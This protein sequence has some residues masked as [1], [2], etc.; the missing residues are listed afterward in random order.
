M[1]GNFSRNK[2]RRAEYTVRDHFRG[3]GYTCDRVPLSGA[4][5]GFKGDLRVSDGIITFYVEVKSR[6]AGFKRLYDLFGDNLDFPFTI[7]VTYGSKEVLLSN[8]FAG[9]S[10]SAANR[11]ILTPEPAL[12]YRLDQLEVLKQECEFLVVKDD[13]RPLLFMKYKNG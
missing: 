6:Q 8:S 2:G 9:L 12:S 7:M 10:S 3:L 11:Y 4:S 5:Q 13:R 1:S